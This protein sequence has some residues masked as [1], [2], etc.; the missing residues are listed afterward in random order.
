MHEQ[1]EF[2]FNLPTE[3]PKVTL[4]GVS[5]QE[6]QNK[7]MKN[8]PY[9][10]LR[11]FEKGGVPSIRESFLEGIKRRQALEFITRSKDKC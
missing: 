1:Y 8:S 4:C 10:C 3:K 5:S 9:G 7:C 11:C 6:E 2:D